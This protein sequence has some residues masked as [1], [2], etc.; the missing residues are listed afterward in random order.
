MD[1][2]FAELT[3]FEATK[4]TKIH[5]R[6]QQMGSKWI[7]TIDGLDTDL[8]VARIAKAM[9]KSLHCAA[10]VTKSKDEE[11]IIQLQGDQRTLIT[12]WLINNEVVT[13]EEAV[14]RVVVHGS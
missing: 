2:T 6:A 3:A 10:T 13:A 7:T 5:V 8:D 4:A 9:K 11:D 12:E 1:L 14:E